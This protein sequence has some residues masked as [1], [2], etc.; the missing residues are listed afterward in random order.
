MF[1]WSWTHTHTNVEKVR[2]KCVQCST[3]HKLVQNCKLNYI[4]WHT[5]SIKPQFSAR[6]MQRRKPITPFQGGGEL[7]LF[8]VSSWLHSTIKEQIHHSPTF[9]SCRYFCSE[10]LPFRHVGSG[11]EVKKQWKERER[12]FISLYIKSI[13]SVFATKGQ[14]L[15]F[16]SLS[17][18]TGKVT[19]LTL[20]LPAVMMPAARHCGSRGS[21]PC[22]VL[23]VVACACVSCRCIGDTFYCS[24]DFLNP[25]LCLYFGLPVVWP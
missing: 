14:G 16:H 8:T 15:E 3:G 1:A 19:V 11:K 5:E 24:D 13:M 10:G 9:V 21:P 25:V 2:V 18:T 12:L 22:S 7:L 4:F 17:C 23:C 6:T 20:C